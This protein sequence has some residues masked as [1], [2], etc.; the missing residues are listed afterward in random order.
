VTN[1]CDHRLS[2]NVFRISAF[3]QFDNPVVRLLDSPSRGPR[4]SKMELAGSSSSLQLFDLQINGP[5]SMVIGRLSS[6][7]GLHPSGLWGSDGVKTPEAKTPRVTSVLRHSMTCRDPSGCHVS[8]RIV[9]SSG[10]RC[11]NNLTLV[12]V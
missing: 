3:R 12:I 5:Q 9:N 4:N 8:L 1:G 7:P 11:Q 6:T 2:Q 10:L